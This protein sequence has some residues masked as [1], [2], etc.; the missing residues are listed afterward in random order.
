MVYFLKYIEYYT[1]ITLYKSVKYHAQAFG[2]F[3]AR[4]NYFYCRKN[5]HER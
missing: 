5:V 2:H 3:D 4:K 1:L